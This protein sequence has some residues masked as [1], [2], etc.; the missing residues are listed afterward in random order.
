M[1]EVQQMID[2]SHLIFEEKADVV[3]KLNT[4]IVQKVSN[5]EKVNEMKDLGKREAEIKYNT[6]KSQISNEHKKEITNLKEQYEYLLSEKEKELEKF[7]NEFKE[8]H[9]QKKTEIHD[10][11]EEIVALYKGRYL[12]LALVEFLTLNDNSV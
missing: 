6:I 4:S 5:T 9:A 12:A 11:R 8:Y 3:H 10:A 2:H 7:V 1:E